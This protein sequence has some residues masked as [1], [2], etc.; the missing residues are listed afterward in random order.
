M[1]IRD[2]TNYIESLAPLSFQE[3]Y[4]NAGLI[5]GNPEAKVKGILIS[6]DVT[7]AV[8]R[9]AVEKNVNLIIAHHPVVFKG[10]KRFTGG[11]YV[12]RTVI[13]AIKNDIAIYA[14]H[15]NL[16]NI[17]GGVNSKICEILD[18]QDCKVLSPATS[19]LKK[20]A[21]Y[22]PDNKADTVRQAMFAAG[23][24]HIGNYEQCSYNIK[25]NGTFKGNENTNPYVGNKGKLHVEPETR[26]ETIVPAHKLSGVIRAMIK[27]HPYEEVAY[28]IFP[29]D[30][31]YEKAG[32]GMLG[33]LKQPMPEIDFLNLIKE[34]F[35]TGIIKYT[36]LLGKDIKTVALCG[37]ACS[38]MLK[39]AIS[40]G[41]DIFISGDFKYHEFFDAEGKIIIADIGHYE[42]EQYTK[43]LFFELLTKKFNT[44]ACYLAQTNTNPIKY[45]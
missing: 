12:E 37:G 7:E 41:A 4:D 45:L 44:F 20:I 22:V 13:S 17:T 3:S 32:T 36:K 26:I 40:A 39:K 42:S 23:A 28:D 30:N 29:L 21:C 25:G 8:V 33:K 35:N 16:D 15:T 24:G 5:V 18:L 11:N 9:E 6:L 19:Q 27:A 34:K 14:A 31:N 2:I 43:E 1:I 38:F 10:L